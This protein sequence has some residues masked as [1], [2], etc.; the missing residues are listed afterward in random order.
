MTSNPEPEGR[1]GSTKPK[2]VCQSA[3]NWLECLAGCLQCISGHTIHA[4]LLQRVSKSFRLVLWHSFPQRWHQ[5]SHE[6]SCHVAHSRLGCSAHL[7][8]EERQSIRLGFQTFQGRLS[9]MPD[10]HVLHAPELGRIEKA[11]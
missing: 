3:V 5:F 7:L 9:S 10:L 8:H 6:N 4:A 11:T 2:E 1:P